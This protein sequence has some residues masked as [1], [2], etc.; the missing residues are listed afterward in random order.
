MGEFA[1]DERN[2]SNVGVRLGRDEISSLIN[3]S[4]FQEETAQNNECKILSSNDELRGLT[5]MLGIDKYHTNRRVPPHGRE[6]RKWRAVSV[7]TEGNV[8]RNDP[9]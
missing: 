8:V 4:E 5:L 1:R 2:P 9:N 3:S 7:R 6:A